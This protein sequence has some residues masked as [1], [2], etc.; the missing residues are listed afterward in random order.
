MIIQG[1]VDPEFYSLSID[2][3]VKNLLS[4][5]SIVCDQNGVAYLS[6]PEPIPFSTIHVTGICLGFENGNM[7]IQDEDD[8]EY[9]HNMDSAFFSEYDNLNEFDEF[10]GKEITFSYGILVEG[11]FKITLL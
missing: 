5:D 7:L 11:R 2:D 4:G 3:R 1:K 8:L 6:D 9:P 10:I